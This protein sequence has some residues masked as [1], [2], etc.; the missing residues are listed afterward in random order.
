[1]AIWRAQDRV[2]LK[3][4][5]ADRMLGLA[6]QGLHSTSD[7]G[8]RSFPVRNEATN[9]L[10]VG[11]VIPVRFTA[12]DVLASEAAVFVRAPVGAAKAP[13][14]HLLRALFDLTPS[15]VRVARI[16]AS[17][18]S[19]DE[20]AVEGRGSQNTVRVKVRGVLEKTGYA[21]CRIV[22]Y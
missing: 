18:K 13:P 14:T 2:R 12:R 3:G 7:E 8:A 21:R 6:L 15:E 5:N 9:E 4:R 17:G 16:P 1:M 19:V 10:S 11:H 20:I 22:I